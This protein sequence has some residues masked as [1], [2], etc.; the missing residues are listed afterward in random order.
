[1][2]YG[3]PTILAALLL[4]GCSATHLVYVHDASMGLDIAVSTEGTQR[5]VFGYDRD[6]YALILLKKD[7]SKDAMSLAAVSCIHADGL[8]DIDFN[9]FVATGSAALQVAA[10]PAGL[11]E[12]R[13]SIFGAE[14]QGCGRAP[15]K[16]GA[17]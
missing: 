8:T 13:S 15:A 9:H 16:I 5:L 12:I 14:D 1:M 6:T 11:A 4:L 2:R 3:V 17:Q 10:D 7:G